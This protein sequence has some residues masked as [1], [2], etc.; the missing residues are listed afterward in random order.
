MTTELGSGSGEVFGS[1]LL[2]RG[3]LV[4]EGWNIVNMT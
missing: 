1:A 2:D 3:L 4:Q